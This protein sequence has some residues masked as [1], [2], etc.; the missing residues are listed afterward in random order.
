MQF[1]VPLSTPGSVQ[2]A[3][4]EQ[5]FAV[6]GTYIEDVTPP[7]SA[8]A[9]Q[10][11]A[12]LVSGSATLDVQ[13]KGLQSGTIY[14][15]GFVNIGAGGLV[16]PINT[17]ID[18]SFQITWNVFATITPSTWIFTVAAL[19][20][21]VGSGTSVNVICNCMSGGGG[22]LLAAGFY[23]ALDP[24]V[25]TW[26]AQFEVGATMLQGDGVTF[27]LPPDS[28]CLITAQASPGSGSPV[29]PFA[30]GVEVAGVA[31]AT[32][33]SIDVEG[34]ALGTTISALSV[35][36][37]MTTVIDSTVNSSFTFTTTADQ[38]VAFDNGLVCTI[39][40]FTRP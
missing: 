31:G 33:F 14:T 37:S 18:Q 8:T 23:T 39:L 21:M 40:A 13:V 7:P 16:V 15:A 34:T 12:A 2:I 1:S 25:P 32:G 6:D 29:T 24:S 17:A 4:T 22:G 28:I 3:Q 35:P 5:F 38:N 20:S 9:L 26:A 19:L 10:L 36:G 30:Y 27:D 11:Y